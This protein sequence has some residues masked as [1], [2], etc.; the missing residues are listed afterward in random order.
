MVAR[1]LLYG[2]LRTQ[3]YFE[4]FL[5]IHFRNLGL[6]FTQIG[7][8]IGFREVCVNALSLATGALADS[9]GYARALILGQI[10]FIVSFVLLGSSGVM[11]GLYAAMLFFA[12]GDTLRSGSHTAYMFRWLELRGRASEYTRL[13]GQTRTASKAGALVAV[14]LGASALSAYS[15]TRMLFWISIIPSVLNVWNLGGYPRL[16]HEQ[17]VTVRAVW[18]RLRNITVDLRNVDLRNILTCSTLFEGTYKVHKDYLQPLVRSVAV[19]GS[20]ILGFSPTLPVLMGASY[21]AVQMAGG[22]ASMFAHGLLRRRGNHRSTERAI[23]GGQIVIY[24][25]LGV[26]LILWSPLVAILGFVALALMQNLW[27]PVAIAH[28]G[29]LASRDR[30]TTIFSVES[31][32][33]SIVAA[34]TAPCVGILVDHSGSLLPVAAI[35]VGVTILVGTLLRR[36]RMTP[37][38]VTSD[39]SVINAGAK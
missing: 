16:T 37:S 33:N 3:Y 1:F 18:S 38:S 20:S 35:G 23:L 17:R 11:P 2:F 14:A 29:A 24:L 39:P 22:V 26:S 5:I 15:S 36:F 10:C 4:F 9:W 19:G 32:G 34:L 28:I 12:A 7:L 21:A 31:Q 25:L 8:L 30:K 6:S 27:R 13:Y